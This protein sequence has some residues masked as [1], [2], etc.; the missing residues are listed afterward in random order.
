[1]KIYATVIAFLAGALTPLFAGTFTV[2]NTADSGA[3][4]LRDAITLANTTAGADTI[5]FNIPGGGVHTIA[6]LSALPTIT[7]AVTINGYSQPGAAPNTDPNGFNGTLLIELSGTDAGQANGL[8]ITAGNSVVKGL[9]INRFQG[10]TSTT[11]NAITLSTGGGN[12]IEGN[13]LGTSADGTSD[14]GNQDNAIVIESGSNDNQI[15]GTTPAARNVIS[16]ND[17]VAF[18]ILT[19]GNII[20]GNFIGNPARWH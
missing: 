13:F 8:F 19:S 18:F 17:S 2:S 1:M 11:G 5:A 4:S 7:E 15:G 9:V 14:L 6:L 12:H 16:G 3:G 20:Q 10:T